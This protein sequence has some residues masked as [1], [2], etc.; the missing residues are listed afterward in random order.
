L[1]VRGEIDDRIFD[2]PTTTHCYL[3]RLEIDIIPL[4][5]ADDRVTKIVIRLEVHQPDF[6][7][8]LRREVVKVVTQLH[9]S[10]LACGSL[11]DCAY[12]ECKSK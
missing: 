2:S 8:D 4:G 9:I 5:F 12:G 1:I 7:R 11:P 3:L 10:E 6:C